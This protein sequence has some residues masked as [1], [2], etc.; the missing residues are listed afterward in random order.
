[1]NHAFTRPGGVWADDTDLL[2]AE[3]ADI[4]AKTVDSLSATGGTY[5]LTE[6]MVIGGAPSIAWEFDLPVEFADLAVFDAGI[7]VFGNAEFDLGTATFAGLV[8]FQNDVQFQT[9][10]FFYDDVTFND[11]VAIG[12]GHLLDVYGD[13]LF[14]AGAE[15][16]GATLFSFGATFSASAVFNGG[17]T[18]GSDASDDIELRGILRCGGTGR[19]KQRQ[20]V[21]TD[22]DAT[23]SPTTATS[24]YMPAGV[25]TTSRDATINDT[26]AVDGDRMRF[27]TLDG[28]HNWAIKRPGGIVVLTYLK[29]TSGSLNWCDV[30]RINGTWEVQRGP[31][32]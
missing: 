17:M 24:V 26:G 4:D 16:Q 3:M 8:D 19:I 13:A 15:F 21:A 28:S 2:P 20:Q 32:L 18:L 1:M 9:N 14:H 5:A 27:T 7:R 22:A 6:R 12:A 29:N 25:M 31:V 30:E 23:F 11:D 10:V